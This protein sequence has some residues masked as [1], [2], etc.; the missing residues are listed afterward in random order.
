MA[1]NPTSEPQ[2]LAAAR[3]GD[4]GAFDEL[5]AEHRAALHAHCYRLLGSVS[6]AEDALQ[7]ALL[8][9]WQGLAGFEGRSSL[10]SWLYSIATHAALRLAAKRPRRVVALEQFPAGDPRPTW[11]RRGRRSRGSSRTPSRGTSWRQ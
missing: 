1:R 10:R 11:V 4:R 7:E 8:G 9:A 5:V 2:A 3:S 6:D